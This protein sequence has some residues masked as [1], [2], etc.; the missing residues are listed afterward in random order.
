[1]IT[2]AYIAGY[3]LLSVRQSRSGSIVNDAPTSLSKRIASIIETGGRFRERCAEIVLH[4]CSLSSMIS[5]RTVLHRSAGVGNLSGA[6]TRD[7]LSLAFAL[8]SLDISRM[9]R[10]RASS[11]PRPTPAHEC[12]VHPSIFTEAIP[13]A[14][15]IASS[16]NGR[17]CP[18]GSGGSS[19]YLSRRWLMIARRRTDFPVPLSSSAFHDELK[20]RRSA[21][22]QSP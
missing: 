6:G 11:F 10:S 18:G 1:M 12:N 9:A 5:V 7:S 13:V 22:L 2:P 20:P 19:L 8:L 15:V 14:A 3:I 16:S 17:A 4:V 21:Y